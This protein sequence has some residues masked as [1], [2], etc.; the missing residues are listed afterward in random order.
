MPG[1]REVRPRTP[2]SA[3]H[4]GGLIVTNAHLGILAPRR[5]S[6]ATPPGSCTTRLWWPNA[7][8]RG[9]GR[10]SMQSKQRPRPRNGGAV[11]TSR[12]LWGTVRKPKLQALGQAP[13][14]VPVP[15]CELI[16]HLQGRRLRLTRSS[17]MSR[18]ACGLTAKARFFDGGSRVRRPE[19]HQRQSD[20]P[21]PPMLCH[22]NGSQRRLRHPSSGRSNV[23]GAFGRAASWAGSKGPPLF[24][25]TWLVRCI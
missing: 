18:A 14:G 23:G 4:Q 13:A 9:N 20:L 11:A 8:A 3:A 7:A 6:A 12:R 10:G 15:A 16:P 19:T 2:A 17:P 25:P 1:A 22:R 24:L 21:A 5:T